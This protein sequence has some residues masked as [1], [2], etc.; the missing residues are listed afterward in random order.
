MSSPRFSEKLKTKK[1]SVVAVDQTNSDSIKPVPPRCRQT[2]HTC[3]P[4]HLPGPRPGPWGPGCPL[5]W[6]WLWCAAPPAEPRGHRGPPACP[7]RWLQNPPAPGRVYPATSSY[8][9]GVCDVNPSEE[10]RWHVRWMPS[11]TFA[12]GSCRWA[13][14]CPSVSSA[15]PPPLV[16]LLTWRRPSRVSETLTAVKRSGQ[17]ELWFF[18]VDIKGAIC[19]NFSLK[20]SKWTKIINRLWKNKN[21]W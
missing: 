20:H 10:A 14:L 9:R 6:A 12:A 3:S 1:T 18:L 13:S 15:G 19:K 7:S 5:W 17:R 16:S 4:L 11:L 2:L 8:Q 21:V